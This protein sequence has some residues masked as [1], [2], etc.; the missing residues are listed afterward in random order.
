MWIY[1]SIVWDWNTTHVAW[2]ILQKSFFVEVGFLMFPGSVS[3]EDEC[4]WDQWSWLWL[5]WRLVWNR[6]TFQGDSW[7]MPMT[8]EISSGEPETNRLWTLIII[9]LS[10]INL[11]VQVSSNWAWFN[12]SCNVCGQKGVLFRFQKEVVL[13]AS[14][15]LCF[16]YTLDRCGDQHE[17]VDDPTPQSHSD[18]GIF[19]EQDTLVQAPYDWSSAAW[20]DDRCHGRSDECFL[21]DPLLGQKKGSWL[22]GH[23]ESAGH[24]RSCPDRAIG[25]LN[26]GD[27][28]MRNRV[29]SKACTAF[30][31]GGPRGWSGAT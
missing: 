27:A 7:V 31:G 4:P 9:I 23:P 5:S 25:C 10:R 20:H 2:E 19:R 18:E 30:S 14:R 1:D 8:S 22:M 11:L 13:E 16:R 24:L 3:H 21:L 29:Q 28:R 26:L 17:N 15:H 6:V 12:F